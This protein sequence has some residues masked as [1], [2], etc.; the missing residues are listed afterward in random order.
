MNTHENKKPPSEEEYIKICASYLKTSA[1]HLKLNELLKEHFT[2][3]N[4]HNN[5]QL[6]TQNNESKK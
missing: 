2:T 4:T 6:K 1:R 5:K 3:T